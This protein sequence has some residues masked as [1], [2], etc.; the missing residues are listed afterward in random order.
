MSFFDFPFHNASLYIV[1]L[2]LKRAVFLDRDGTLIRE[3]D[4]LPRPH[5]IDDLAGAA[6]WILHKEAADKTVASR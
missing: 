5:V 4:Y 2:N 1:C 6:A 3:M